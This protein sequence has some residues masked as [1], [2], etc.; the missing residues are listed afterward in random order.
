MLLVLVLM[1]SFS[2][3][4]LFVAIVPSPSTLLSLLLVFLFLLLPSSFFPLV[5]FFP[6]R[7][8]IA[9]LCIFRWMLPRKNDREHTNNSNNSRK[10]FCCFFIIAAFLPLLFFCLR[11]KFANT[12]SC[13]LYKLGASSCSSPL[14]PS[15]CNLDEERTRERQRDRERRRQRKPN[16]AQ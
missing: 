10:A 1:F 7:L 16:I 3:F 6:P 5:L 14:A 9:W 2:L 13:W 15:L 11:G 8:P 4:F 12:A